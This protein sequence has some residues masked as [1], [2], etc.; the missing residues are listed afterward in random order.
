MSWIE[1]I[2]NKTR[3]EKLKIIWT[4]AIAVALLLIIVWFFFAPVS[5][6]KVKDK[7]LFQTIGRGFKDVRENLHR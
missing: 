6:Y 2:Q 5:K 4:V 1:K 7:T 3:A